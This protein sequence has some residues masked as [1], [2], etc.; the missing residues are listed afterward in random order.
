MGRDVRG[1]ERSR[2]KT[3]LRQWAERRLPCCLMHLSLPQPL[4]PPPLC[5]PFS[6]G[7]LILPCPCFPASLAP[8]PFSSYSQSR[9]FL[10]REVPTSSCCNCCS[11]PILVVSPF[12]SI[13]LSSALFIHPWKSDNKT[14]AQTSVCILGSITV[15]ALAPS[16]CLWFLMSVSLLLGC[17]HFSL[18]ICL[19]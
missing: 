16:S 7:A 10:V 3:P 19:S 13:F 6:S 18:F 4:R 8:V 2:T 11:W 14:Q 12:P 17:S 15:D 5:P 9:Y 1:H